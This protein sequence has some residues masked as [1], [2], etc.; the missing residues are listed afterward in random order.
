[1]IWMLALILL[2]VLVCTVAVSF[3]IQKRTNAIDRIEQAAT[4]AEAASEEVRDYVRQ[5]RANVDDNREQAGAGDA[6]IASALVNISEIEALLRQHV[7]ED[8]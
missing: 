1:M 3:Q 8:Q 6:A 7:E 5:L 2:I 4:E